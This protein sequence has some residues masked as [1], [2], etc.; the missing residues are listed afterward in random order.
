MI[1]LF[2]LALGGCAL[3]AYHPDFTTQSEPSA[4]ELDRKQELADSLALP[5]R[6]EGLIIGMDFDVA[7]ALLK[8]KL[9]RIAI[10]DSGVEYYRTNSLDGYANVFIWFRDGRVAHWVV[11]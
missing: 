7:Q 4:L 11:E 8:S 5:S 3:P 10:L 6:A 1:F 9:A 2:S